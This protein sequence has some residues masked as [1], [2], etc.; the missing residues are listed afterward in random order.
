MAS[1]NGKVV[2][3]A[4]VDKLVANYIDTRNYIKNLKK[5]HEEELAE[6]ELALEK[7]AGRLLLFLDSHG[8]EMARTAAGTVSATSRDTASLSDPDVFMGFVAE[9]GLFELLDRRA[10]ATACKD[11]AKDTGTLPPGV[12]INTLRGVS[13]RTATAER[14]KS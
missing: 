9:H 5:K 14:A 3:D 11:F 6:F 10:N 13:V 8:Q 7:L 12:R 1:G 2:A 4:R